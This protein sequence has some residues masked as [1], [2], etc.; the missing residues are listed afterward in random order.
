MNCRQTACVKARENKASKESL[1]RTRAK[2]KADA[3]SNR[4]YFT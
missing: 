3:A 2:Q 1:L 4:Y